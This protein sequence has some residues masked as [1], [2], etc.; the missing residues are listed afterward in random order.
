MSTIALFIILITSISAFDTGF[1]HDLTVRALSEY[2][3]SDDASNVI[4]LHNWYTDFYSNNFLHKGLKKLELL[5]FDNLLSNDEVK[6]TDVR[7]SVSLDNSLLE[8]IC[9]QC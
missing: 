2:G 1:H 7:Y 4:I 5:H 9:F 3:Y 6:K 8:T